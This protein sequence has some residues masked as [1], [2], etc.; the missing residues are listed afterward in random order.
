MFK[1]I[2]TI[3]T[4]Q[5]FAI[6]INVIR[7]KIIAVLLGPEGVGILS[8]VDQVVQFIAY[9]SVISIPFASVKFLSRSHSEGFEAFR[10]T[11][12][13]LLK[14][15]LWLS[16]SGTIVALCFIIFRA[17]LLGPEISRYKTFLLLALL[18]VPTMVLGGFFSNVL[19]SV[20]KIKAAAMMAVITNMSMT[21]AVYIGISLGGIFGLY[22]GNILTG[23]FITIGIFIYLRK[24]LHLPFYDRAISVFDELKRSPDILPF[25]FMLFITTV[26]YSLSLLAARYSVLKYAG[27]AEAG[28]LQAVMAIGLSINLVLNPANGLFLTPIMNR[29]ISKAEKVRTAIEFQ[30]KLMVVL[31]LV[32]LPITLFPQWVLILLF[33][34]QFI[35]ASQFV[36]LF[37]ISQCVVQL[38]GV[39]QALLIGLDDLK[40]YAFMTCAGFVSMGIFSWLLVPSYGI[41]GV[42][43]GSV[44]SSLAIFFMTWTRVRLAHGF[45]TPRSVSLLMGYGLSFMFLIGFISTRWLDSNMK[46]IFL[47]IGVY[48]FFLMTLFFFLNREEKAFF[49]GFA[50]YK[51]SLDK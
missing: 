33:S 15:L 40:S 20:Q 25:S 46:T 4:I 47:K 11:Y 36:F 34:P 18:G 24:I 12:S 26:V 44:F 50:G 30:K 14:A 21:I 22:S 3:G 7:S 29:N 13:S 16:I 8:I 17:D 1:I 5:I 28:L 41:L 37:V 38:A 49:F 45:S 31:A 43:V 35:Q 2:A 51:L 9:L 27:E 6:F 19:A 39:N 48:L 42:A 23:V 32:A 10:R